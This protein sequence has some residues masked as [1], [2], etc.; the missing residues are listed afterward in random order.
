MAKKL[1]EDQ[2]RYNRLCSLE[3]LTLAWDR[4]N[5]AKNNISYKNFYRQQF[6]YYEYD[7]YENLE[8]LSK[9]LINHSYEP[10]DGIKF[11]KP[12]QSG[13]QRP[14]TFLEIEDLIVY[15]AIANIV[16]LPLAKKRLPYEYKNLFSNIFNSDVDSNIF[17]FRDWKKCYEKFKQNISNNFTN[18]L[19]YT[20][21]FDLAAYYDTIDHGSLLSELFRDTNSELGSLLKLCLKKWENNTT[22]ED[23]K[24]CH[25]IPQGP[26]ASSVFGELF[27][28]SIDKYMIDSG[29]NYSRYVD[30]IV[31]QSETIEEVQKAIIA[32]D[33]KCKEKGL[34]PQS[35]KLSIFKAENE[36][37]A[38]GKNQS[39][40]LEHKE[41]ILSDENEALKTFINAFREE[42]FDSS[43]I[44]YLLKVYKKSDVLLKKVLEEFRNHYEFA[45]EFCIY[46]GECIPK[47][48]S[49]IHIFVASLM[50]N[51]PPYEG[52]EYETW[53]LLTKLNTY[54]YSNRFAEKAITRLKETKSGIVKYGIYCYLATLTDNRFIGFL[55]HEENK[56]ILFLSINNMS[57]TIINR[58][59]FIQLVNFYAERNSDVLSSLLSRHLY[60]QHL[61]DDISDMKYSEYLKR[62][63]K[64]NT[65]KYETISYYLSKD[66]NIKELMNWDVFLAESFSHANELFYNAHLAGKR[67]KST[68]INTMDSFNDIVIRQFIKNLAI[69]NPRQK[70]PKLVTADGNINEIGCILDLGTS[71]AKKY[72]I[73]IKNMHEIHERRRTTP[74]SHAYDL[75]TQRFSSF[76]T[77]EEFK[78][79]YS[80]QKIVFEEIIKI[81]NLYM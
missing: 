75:K 49:L 14:F 8:R 69:W 23:R 58:P 62:L 20:A 6:L 15:Q 10:S 81:C 27:L 76:L 63:P 42:S 39:L 35:S 72:P 73:L 74:L 71:L 16:V 38:I 21:H 4:I 40:T 56:F 9:K 32:L 25:G 80:K 59:D 50:N 17:L 19:I 47:N 41:L 60:F 67:F 3:N 66:Y 79:Y 64:T 34:I 12:K 33:I 70:C 30:D 43:I 46:I 1:S 57:K 68:W 5:S 78:T 2:K 37:D 28:L 54:Y 11:Y 52:V 31:I 36:E 13:L 48:A 61:F 53:V 22:S 7:L 26:L 65:K 55:S 45:E 29:Y 18:G 24:I 51:L 44:R 77:K